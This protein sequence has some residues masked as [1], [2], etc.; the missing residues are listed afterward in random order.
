MKLFFRKYGEGRPL[1]I[2]HGLFGQSDNWNTLS[3]RYAE[4]GYCVYAIDQ[5]NHGLS[6]HS[7]D[8]NYSVMADD[9]SELIQD[10][11]I[12]EPFIIGHSMGGKTVMYF[13]SKYP[14][15]ANKIVVADISP[16]KYLPRNS[17][18]MEALLSVNL[19]QLKSRNE[20]EDSLKNFGL[21]FGTR[22][23]L[24]KNLYR[25][26]NPVEGS[27]LFDWRFNLKVIANHFEN[28]SESVPEFF[29]ETPALFL[30][31]E[32]SDY[33]I[34]DDEAEIFRRFK[35]VKI[36]TVQGSGHW[37]H[38]EKPNEFFQYTVDFFS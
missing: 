4:H 18:V 21:D 35:S 1:I 36:V 6:P 3:K 25:P 20:A 14:G 27:S 30:K 8:W 19:G 16:R 15:I 26:D 37:I 34:E 31:G 33:I 23:F 11:L 2:L 13:D 24:L 9:L 32:L 38:A 22:Q 12:V 17:E 5:R 7:D 28:V 10:E 29:S